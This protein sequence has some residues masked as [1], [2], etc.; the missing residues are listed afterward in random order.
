MLIFLLLYVVIT[1]WV[2]ALGLLSTGPSTLHDV[3]DCAAIALLWPL[4]V[5]AALIL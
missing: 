2:F 4:Y 1:A 5:L 3:M